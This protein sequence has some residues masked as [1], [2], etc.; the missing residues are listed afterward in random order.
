MQR[1]LSDLSD[2]VT[3]LAADPAMPFISAFAGKGVQGGVEKSPLGAA[4]LC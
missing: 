1:L 4:C 2:A 3:L